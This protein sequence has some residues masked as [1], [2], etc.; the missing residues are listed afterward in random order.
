MKVCTFIGH[1]QVLIPDMREKLEI[2]IEAV[3]GTDTE[4]LFY[5]GGMGEFDQLCESVVFSMKKAH[6]ERKIR[7]ILVLPYMKQQI[8][9][10]KE[11]ISKIYDEIMIPEPLI[12]Q[13]YKKAIQLRNRWMVENASVLF[14]CVHRRFGGAYETLC[15]AL[16]QKDIQIINLAE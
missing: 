2:M 8:N 7:L 15:H 11:R 6:P 14:A 9:N 3:L 12:K 16:K 5:S 4:F 13:H 10:E 1:R